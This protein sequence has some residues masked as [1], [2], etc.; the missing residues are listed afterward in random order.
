M[1]IPREGGGD[2]VE[3]KEGRGL[4]KVAGRDE[5]TSIF[6]RGEDFFKSVLAQSQIWPV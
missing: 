3:C 1:S 6:D 2:K 4:P 5:V